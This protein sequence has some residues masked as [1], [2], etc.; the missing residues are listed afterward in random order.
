[1]Y[2]FLLQKSILACCKCVTSNIKNVSHKTRQSSHF[3]FK[4]L[5]TAKDC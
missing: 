1:M 3:V 2:K 4:R 5:Q